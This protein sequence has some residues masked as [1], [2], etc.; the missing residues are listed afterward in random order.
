MS[1][2][3]A[4]LGR[5]GSLERGLLAEAISLNVD[6]EGMMNQPVD[7][8]HGHHGIGEDV[9]PLT[10]RLISGNQEAVALVAMSNELKEDRGFRLRLFDIA[11]V[12][13]NQQIKA[14][15]FGEGDRQEQ[16]GF[17]LLKLLH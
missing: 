9:I 2:K 10:K 12:I 17:S 13:D 6:D 8:G 3:L 4:R 11:E 5:L 16:L 7:G 15:Q 1:D 14:V